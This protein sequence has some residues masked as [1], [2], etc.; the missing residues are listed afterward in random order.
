[1]KATLLTLAVLSSQLTTAVATRLPELKV[2]RLCKLR[3]ADDKIMRQPES[4]SVTD[5]VREEA[6]A[7]QELIKIWASTDSA[8]RARCQGE[9]AVLGTRSYLDYLSCL[10]MADDL[11]SAAKDTRHIGAGK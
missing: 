11:K 8:V 1:M 10:Q 2:E 6:D 9:A 7:K 4:Q 3:S 5:C